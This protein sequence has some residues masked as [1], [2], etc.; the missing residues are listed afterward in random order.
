MSTTIHLAC[1]F[2]PP[3]VKP[4]DPNRFCCAGDA[5]YDPTRCTCWEIVLDMGDQAPPR[6]DVEPEQRSKCCADC[7]YRQGSPER[8][9]GEDLPDDTGQAFWCHDG[10]PKTIGWRHPDGTFIAYD[11]DRADYHPLIIDGVPYR[12]DGRPGARCAGWKAV[13][14]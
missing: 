5:I 4:S 3:S 14:R 12:L 6:A 10:M 9:A 1:G 8:T 7:A 13:A 11:G 2:A